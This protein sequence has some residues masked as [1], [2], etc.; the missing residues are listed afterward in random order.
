MES[1]EHIPDRNEVVANLCSL[2]EKNLSPEERKNTPE[3][4]SLRAYIQFHENK[5]DQYED[6]LE[7]EFRR[8]EFTYELAKIYL[9]AGFV[10]EGKDALAQAL[11]GALSGGFQDIFTEM[12][13]Y[14]LAHV[15]TEDEL[16][17]M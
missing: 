14:F 10:E 15:G 12:R 6:A 17:M 1:H 5:I 8:V 11:N 9:E 13:E 2:H 3:M 16:D 4:V 7:G